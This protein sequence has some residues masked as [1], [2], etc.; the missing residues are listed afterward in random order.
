MTAKS[1]KINFTFDGTS[2]YFFILAWHIQGR[3]HPEESVASAGLIEHDLRGVATVF[4]FVGSSGLFKSR[5][6]ITG[7][8]DMSNVNSIVLPKNEEYYLLLIIS[9][10]SGYEH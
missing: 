1:Y 5:L 3:F 10:G 2:F 6:P 9:L 7:V 8:C 4:E